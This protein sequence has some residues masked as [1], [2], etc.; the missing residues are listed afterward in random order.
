ME[1]FT[2]QQDALRTAF[3][4]VLGFAPRKGSLTITEEQRQKVGDLMMEWLKA[5]RWS[6]RPGTRAFSNPLNYIVGRQPTCLIEAY[7]QPKAK[8][9]EAAPTNQLTPQQ[10]KFDLIKAAVEAGIISKE[11]GAKQFMAILTNS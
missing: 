9:P 11:E 7:V 2:S 6:I 4:Q 8:S 1:K 3:N 5:D 10:Q